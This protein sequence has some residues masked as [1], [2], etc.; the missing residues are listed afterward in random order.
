MIPLNDT[1]MLILYGRSGTIGIVKAGDSNLFLLETEKE[2]IVLGLEPED[3]LIASGF[4]TEINTLK[5][6]K[7][8]LFMIREVGSPFIVLPKHHPATKRLKI[9]T[10]A[11]N[12]TRI[13]C[14]ITPGTH[15]EQDILCGVE[16][17]GGLEILG[18]PGGVDFI[19]LNSGS[20]EKVP[21]II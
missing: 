7:C 13:S 20:I 12:K 15:P 2:E 3:L 1:E 4:D 10:A 14:D 21:F 11:G 16:E 5:A 9:V 19:N 6:I 18:V 8:V 17:F